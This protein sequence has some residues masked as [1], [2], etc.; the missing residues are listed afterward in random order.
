MAR[1]RAFAKSSGAAPS[2]RWRGLRQRCRTRLEGV[3]A[4]DPGERR[5]QPEVV[6]SWL[7][8]CGARRAP[9]IAGARSAQPP[10]PSAHRLPP[11]LALLVG[12]TSMVTCGQAP[13]SVGQRKA[14][15]NASRGMRLIDAG[16]DGYVYPCMACPHCAAT[17][18]TGFL[19]CSVCDACFSYVETA[20]RGSTHSTP[21]VAS[22]NRAQGGTSTCKAGTGRRQDAWTHSSYDC[23]RLRNTH[24]REPCVYTRLL[25]P[26]LSN[27]PVDI[28]GLASATRNI[29]MCLLGAQVVGGRA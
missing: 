28:R 11:P 8:G 16:S 27:M 1:V 20:R 7:L 3:C 19:E 6:P 12:P 5:L 9:I 13:T 15:S 22:R 21:T 26:S 24:V 4:V 25:G 18:A 23:C 10:H 2:P 14:T 17:I 29:N